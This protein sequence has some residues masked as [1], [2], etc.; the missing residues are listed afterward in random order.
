MERRRKM[1]KFRR[2]NEVSMSSNVD[3]TCQ[4]KNKNRNL[5]K[6]QSQSTL[7][8]RTMM[9]NSPPALPPKLLLASFTIFFILFW[10]NIG[11]G[12]IIYISHSH[13]GYVKICEAKISNYKRQKYNVFKCR[14]PISTRHR[15]GCRS[16]HC[17]FRCGPTWFCSLSNYFLI[18][19]FDQ[20][21]KDMHFLHVDAQAHL[22]LRL[23]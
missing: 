9:K 1:I 16:G 18:I 10:Q 13:C 22:G 19:T 8:L 11:K 17:R 15:L 4:R 20:I 3:F 5:W 21:S 12:T 7:Q 6:L 2:F 14:I 23:M